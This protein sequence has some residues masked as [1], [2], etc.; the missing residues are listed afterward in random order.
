MKL[1][2]LRFL[3]TDIFLQKC[4]TYLKKSKS[5][6]VSTICCQ[7]S[8]ED[9]VHGTRVICTSGHDPSKGFGS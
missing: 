7:N 3:E 8:L 4:W 1:L 6:S 2:M 9:N 5:T